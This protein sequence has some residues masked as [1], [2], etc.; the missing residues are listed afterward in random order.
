MV[1]TKSSSTLL[2]F[3]CSRQSLWEAHSGT[4]RPNPPL[5][6]DAT[7]DVVVVGAGF[8]GLSAAW[9]IKQIDPSVS[10]AVIEA[11]EVGF[12]ASGRSA[13]NCFGLFGE[14]L[15][16]VRAIYG[17]RKT[18]EAH[19]YVAKALSYLANLVKQQ[20][21]D[22][23]YES[24]E[25]WRVSTSARLTKRLQSIHETYRKLGLASDF[26]WVPQSTVRE[27][28]PR[29][30]FLAGLAE[31]DCA[32]INPLKHVREWKRLCEEAGVTIFESTPLLGIERTTPLSISTPRGR[33]RAERVMLATNAYS[34]LL[35]GVPE[36]RRKQSPVWTHIIATEPLRPDQRGAIGW[37]GGQGVY[38]CFD[39]LHY[40]RLTADGRV[41]FGGGAPAVTTAAELNDRVSECIWKNLE[42]RLVRYF[43]PLQGIRIEHRWKG[44]IS[45]CADMA[46][47][48]GFLGGDE[49]LLFSCGFVGHGIPITQ[50][51]GKTAAQMICGKSSELT[52]FWAVNR[53]V[54]PWLPAPLDCWTKRG[55]LALMRARDTWYL[56]QSSRT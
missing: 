17:A 42:R 50:L 4:Y 38:D 30:P 25:F 6:G 34:H 31:K 48:I 8:S 41:C 35:A 52:D 40:F 51:N 11:R 53:R 36:L 29:S 44:A 10:V 20:K 15:A 33:L 13:G 16:V 49:R 27:H 18:R 12:G 28:F 37:N 9:H 54:L 26:E 7:A 43:P 45:V 39:Q 47:A 21:M 23:D 55:V 2:E 5:L 46:P 1:S 19:G 32:L 56:G 24:R 14:D 3:A 22:S